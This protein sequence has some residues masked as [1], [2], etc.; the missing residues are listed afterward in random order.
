MLPGDGVRGGLGGLGDDELAV[1]ASAGDGRAFDVLC[2]RY[3]PWLRAYCLRVLRDRDAAEDAAQDALLRAW[4]GLGGRRQRTGFRAWL[5]VIARNVA[6]DALTRDRVRGEVVLEVDDLVA[7]TV[8]VGQEVGVRIR[9][10]E[11]WGD[12]VALPERQRDALTLHELFGLSFAQI[13]SLRGVSSQSARQAA[14]DG[15][16][17][18]GICVIGRERSCGD[19]QTVLTAPDRRGQ[20][21]GWVVAHLRSCVACRSVGREGGGGGAGG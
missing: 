18:L 15:R 8:D 20:R 6:V 2:Q 16:R 5:F 13:A 12:L 11:L 1:L 21:Q 3:R 19:V 4:R 17:G 7:S 9:M 10:Q 14:V